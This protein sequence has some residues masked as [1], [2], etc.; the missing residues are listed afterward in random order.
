M[1]I[2]LHAKRPQKQT[3]PFIY[4]MVVFTLG[5][6]TANGFLFSSVESIVVMLLSFDAH[7]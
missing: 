3:A 7:G 2:E 6:I 4:D 1:G 5:L